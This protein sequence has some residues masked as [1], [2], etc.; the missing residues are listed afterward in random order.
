MMEKKEKRKAK[1][2]RK[3]ER[4]QEKERK[5]DM[6]AHLTVRQTCHDRAKQQK[7]L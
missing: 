7:P 2:E 4:E 5:S 1:K 6:C 3:R